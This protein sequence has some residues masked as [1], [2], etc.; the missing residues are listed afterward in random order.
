MINYYSILLL[1]LISITNLAFSQ[2]KD[3]EDYYVK[4]EVY[5]ELGQFKEAI[6]AYEVAIAKDNTN[7]KYKYRLGNVILKSGN[8][9]EAIQ[10]FNKTLETDSNYIDAH[11]KLAILYKEKKNYDKAIVHLDAAFNISTNNDRKIAYKTRIINLLDKI[12]EFDKA[13]V[14]IA[15]AKALDPRNNYVLYMDA[16]YNNYITKNYELAKSSMQ[17]AISQMEEDKG[18]AH[19][20]YYYELGFAHHSLEEYQNANIAFKEVR[21]D[22]LRSKVSS[23]TPEYFYQVASAYYKTYYLAEAKELLQAVIKMDDKFEPAYD[24]LIELE[25]NQLNRSDIVKLLEHKVSIQEDNTQK[26]RILADLI[27]LELKYNDLETCFTHIKEFDNCGI[28]LPNVMFMEAKANALRKEY[29][30]SEDILK[31]IIENYK[32]SNIRFK[33]LFLLGMIY[34]EQGKINEA[35]LIYANNFPGD[36]N[37]AVREQLKHINTN[38][39]ET[40][41][42]KN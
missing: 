12:G 10:M 5:A 38:K 40:L 2:N 13:G 27:D 4:G 28:P 23:M 34:E 25:E 8:R 22:K 24:L 17:L 37:V 26:V 19:E 9:N 3:A 14:H 29:P 21:N 39:K 6:M 7:P 18:K 35:K 16:K 30:R 33:C 41:V 20:H 42:K 15:D 36:F 32:D 1:F 31:Q 11:L